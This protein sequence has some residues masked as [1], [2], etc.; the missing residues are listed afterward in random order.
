MSDLALEQDSRN[1]EDSRHISQADT[2]VPKVTEGV[3][4]LGHVFLVI[5]Q[6]S[7]STLRKAVADLQ[8]ENVISGALRTLIAH[9]E[10][11]D[12]N[13]RDTVEMERMQEISRPLLDRVLKKSDDSGKKV[14]FA[15]LDWLMLEYP[16][17]QL[18]LRALSADL[19]PLNDKKRK[20]AVLLALEHTLQTQRKSRSASRKTSVKS[21]PIMNTTQMPPDTAGKDMSSEF[22]LDGQ[23][24]SSWIALIADI[25]HNDGAI[26][27]DGTRSMTR[28]TTLA[29]DISIVLSGIHA[30]QT[31]QEITSEETARKSLLVVEAIS[32]SLSE[33]NSTTTRTSYVDTLMD[34]MASMHRV[35]KDFQ[36]W[37]ARENALATAAL[38]D[39]LDIIL[40]FN[41][42]QSKNRAQ[43]PTEV[44]KSFARTW[45]VISSALGQRSIA[46]A[47]TAT[48]DQARTYL[49]MQDIPPFLRLLASCLVLGF[50]SSTTPIDQAIQKS[51]DIKASLLAFSNSTLT[52]DIPVGKHAALA[53]QDILIP[54]LGEGG[55]DI[56]K[57]QIIT[58][59]SSTA[60]IS[61]SSA[62]M[63]AQY[64]M[65][66]PAFIIPE[67]LQRL[68]KTGN[69][70]LANDMQLVKTRNTLRI[71]EALTEKDY[72]LKTITSE[73]EK[74][75]ELLEDAVIGLL[76]DTDVMVRLTS[77]QIVATLD[78]A[79]IVN[80]F[81][82]DLTLTDKGA[83]SSAE[84]VLLECMLSQRKDG[85]L[86][87]GFS[88]FLDYIRHFNNAP[89]LDP[90]KKGEVSKVKSPAQLFSKT[91]RTAVRSLK[92]AEVEESLDRLFRVVKKLGE[93]IPSLLWSSF[94]DCLVA[95]TY[96]S[97][98]D[99]LLIRVWNNFAP[100]IANSSDAIASLITAV[101]EL[102][103]KQGVV[104]EDML[105]HALEASDEAID[106]LR[107]ARLSPLLILKT[108]PP[109]AIARYLK[110]AD[111]MSA[112]DGVESISHK[113]T[114]VLKSRSENEL[115]FGLVRKL[116][117]GILHGMFPDSSLET[118]HAHLAKQFTNEP[119]RLE[120]V[121]LED[122]RSWIFALYNWVLNWTIQS[123]SKEQTERDI[124]WLYRI[125]GDF[126]YR[127]MAITNLGKEQDLYKLQLGALDVLS[128]ILLA[129]AP[130]YDPTKKTLFSKRL[131]R[132]SKNQ[133][134]ST[135]A[136]IEEI[137]DNEQDE[138][139]DASSLSPKSPEDLFI[140]LLTD[141]LSHII[142]PMEGQNQSRIPQAVCLANVL[143]MTMQSLASGTN[144]TI[145]GGTVSD[146]NV[147]PPS[148]KW[149]PC[150]IMDLITPSLG[151]NLTS[152]LRDDDLAS[153]GHYTPLIQACIQILYTGASAAATVEER[154]TNRITNHWAMDVAVL[155]LG[156]TEFGVAVA[157]LK[158]LATM[159]ATKMMTAE[160]LTATNLAAIRKGFTRL[161]Q[162]KELQANEAPE[163][164]TLLDKMWEMVA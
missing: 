15:L 40:R 155:G 54:V 75:R 74:Y 82:Y 30:D 1:I 136:K 8:G 102:M 62:S 7:R 68:Q 65:V 71:V 80:K 55:F 150:L 79:K 143:V 135:T 45:K 114:R 98:T 5:F 153:D 60:N 126:F 117:L 64:T 131:D 37:S 46:S 23:T 116:A 17:R 3:K 43:P 90:Y 144:T 158:L 118:V 26:A 14:A 103:E 36:S 115:E 99:H 132:I 59:L 44:I 11:A 49:Q 52:E 124:A 120:R 78:P 148:S 139:E 149:T 145:A 38:I 89:R 6:A 87:G 146:V 81:A 39:T 96:G 63:I 109:Y 95:K 160:L 163:I 58:I 51:G 152:I 73:D 25:I 154:T 157:S 50:C 138:K 164:T 56:V 133:A 41:K 140:S 100:S 34:S 13:D 27:S 97:P 123:N 28:L 19:A 57:N 61:E 161:H 66:F 47:L 147:H 86:G 141:I 91:K 94:I 76:Q 104:T 122:G 108:V 24:L 88:A 18:M 93:S 2:A 125:I 22:F 77:S 29:F 85:S 129:T 12:G 67:L 121:D 130:F 35:I 4:G 21:S 128:K 113:I 92:Q 111:V 42:H 72:F 32:E 106:E 20:L 16:H 48:L 112:G 142:R 33:G 69:D 119:S 159:S 53:L 10:V 137:D 9:V 134:P 105:D 31:L 83:A 156:C 107:L 151:A 70:L 162:S 101:S 110:T 84:L 127:I